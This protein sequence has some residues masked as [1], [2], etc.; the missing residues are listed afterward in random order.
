MKKKNKQFDINSFGTDEDILHIEFDQSVD[1]ECMDQ[2][3]EI[4][5]TFPEWVEQEYKEECKKL[6][7]ELS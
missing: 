5:D 3:K 6:A 7:G 2:L 1:I 4:P